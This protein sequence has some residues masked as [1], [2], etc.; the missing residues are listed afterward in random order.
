[1]LL[2]DGMAGNDKWRIE[3]EY[4]ESCNCEL[5]CPCLLSNSQARPT[6]GHCDVVLAFHIKQGNYGGVDI[7]GLNAVHALTTP[8]PMAKGGGTLAVYIDA[9]AN[10]DQRAALEAIFTGAAGGPPALFGPII[11]NVLPTRSVPIS[12]TG[13]GK[14]FHLSI[15]N[16]T[17]V[18]VE[19][20]EAAGQ[21]WLENVAHPA[22]TRLAVARSSSSRFKD[23]SLTFDNSGRNGH[24]SPISWSNS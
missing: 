15:P 23:H 1:L 18:S 13:D 24:F 19:G 7:S 3:G 21:V 12:F 4:F 8:G 17:D 20:I 14:K 9:L 6:E 5:L 11:S 16:V 2:E 10:A 22:S